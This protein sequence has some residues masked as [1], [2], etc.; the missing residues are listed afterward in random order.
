MKNV[1]VGR[2][3]G[4]VLVAYAFAV[5]MLGT[6]LPTPLYP[7]YQQKLGFSSLLVT[8]IYAVYAIGVIAALLLFGQLSD[9][10][11]RRWVLLGSLLF[12]AASAIVFLFV[13]SLAPLFIGRILSGLSA[14]IITGTATATLVDLAPQG[15][16]RRATLIATGVNM[17]GL[18]LGPLFAGILAQYAA[19][20]LQLVF[21]MDLV[22]LVP[23]IIGI[24][25]MPEP[26]ER[27]GPFRLRLQRLRIPEQVRATFIRAAIPGFVGFA[28][29][30]LF[31]AVAPVF[32]SQI[33]HLPNHALTGL[34]GFALF[35]SSTLGQL[36]LERFPQN[37]V[38]PIGCVGLIL[39]IAVIAGG[40]Q[41][42]SLTLLV[43]GAV[44]SGFGQGLS[45]RA[46]LAAINDQSPS[47]QR[48]EVASSY[49]TVL[50]VAI[51]L[52]I[53]GIGVAAQIFGLQLAGI[54]FSIIMALLALLA[55]IL[56]VF[57]PTGQ[58]SAS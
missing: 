3:P 54:A 21:I 51:S 31:T 27:K 20:P 43:A 50:Y 55:L 44:I 12:S 33:L 52:P 25:I 41:V 7:I 58:N 34:V 24:L 36:F 10:I 53:I 28:V 37:L 18:G 30:G 40:L 13:G 32:L 17:G 35:A 29:L 5:T 57:R 16:Q 49:F 1:S 19:L 15:G 47:G 42:H 46:G 22:L 45:F 23:A 48:S 14:G 56:L 39:G 2:G 11:G 6:T 9:E 8:I 4:F 26:V 38:L